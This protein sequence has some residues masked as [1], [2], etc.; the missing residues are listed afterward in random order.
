MEGVQCDAIYLRLCGLP[1][2]CSG[3]GLMAGVEV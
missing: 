3:W 1:G 2:L